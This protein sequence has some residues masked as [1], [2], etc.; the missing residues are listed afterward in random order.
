M[1]LIKNMKNSLLNAGSSS[2]E[3]FQ[4]AESSIDLFIESEALA[5]VP[6]VEY[7]FSI[8]N[9]KDKYEVAKVTRNY[10]NFIKAASELDTE[11]AL[12]FTDTIFANN[13]KA[14]EASETI[15]DI[16]TEGER[17]LKSE[18]LGNL[19]FHFAKQRLSLDEFNTLM[20][21]IRSASLPSLRSLS[22]FLA[23]T[24][25]SI[26]YHNGINRNEHEALLQAMGAGTRNGTAFSLDYWGIMLAYY[27]FNIEI[28]DFD[29][30][31]S[32]RNRDVSQLLL[33]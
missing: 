14:E 5:E 16:I 6:F 21:L 25:N 18:I 31:M 24:N 30:L 11:E 3:L 32:L 2:T 22:L 27:G 1:N 28:G 26:S 7:A 15:F 19:C 17:P 29:K 33:N 9:A 23:S 10:A 8:K 20:H 12:Y 13:E 4:A